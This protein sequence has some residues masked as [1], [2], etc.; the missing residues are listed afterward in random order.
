VWIFFSCELVPTLDNDG[1]GL[2]STSVSDKAKERILV[3]MT[4]EGDLISGSKDF[5]IS[6]GIRTEEKIWR[7]E[8][9]AYSEQTNSNDEKI[10]ALDIPEGSTLAVECS[11]LVLLRFFPHGSATQWDLFMIDFS[12]PITSPA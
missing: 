11:L 2:A 1:I 8:N 12:F 9:K 7:D 4:T 3:R 5:A 6:S 10:K